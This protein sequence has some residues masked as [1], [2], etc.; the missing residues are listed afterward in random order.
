VI[1]YDPAGGST[2]GS[3]FY[4]VPGQG[5]RKAHFTFDARFPSDGTVPNGTVKLWIPGGELN[6]ESTA[7]EMLVVSG[8]RAQFWGT[9]T[10]NGAPAR[11][12]ITA[13]EGQASGHGGAADAIRIELWDASG[14]TL[15]YDTQPGAAQDAPVT[16]EIDGGNIKINR[17]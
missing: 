17:E 2:T 5:N 12:R 9:G 11:F 1:V 7:I 3:G 15:V 6:F 4:T 13:I 14:A 10:L 8:N 16:T